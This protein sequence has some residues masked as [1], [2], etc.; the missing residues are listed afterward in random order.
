MNTPR[1]SIYIVSCLVLCDPPSYSVCTPDCHVTVMWVLDIVLSKRIPE[2]C[3]LLPEAAPKLRPLPHPHS[4]QCSTPETNSKLKLKQQYVFIKILNL[5]TLQSVNHWSG[6]VWTFC[7]RCQRQQNLGKKRKM[8]LWSKL[9]RLPRLWVL[10]VWGTPPARREREQ[11]A[12]AGSR[13]WQLLLL[14]P[15]EVGRTCCD[16]RLNRQLFQL[17]PTHRLVSVI[18]YFP[19]LLHTLLQFQLKHKKNR[20]HFLRSEN[21]LTP[22]R[23]DNVWL[24]CSPYVYS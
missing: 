9:L 1:F 7:K 11:A 19:V 2:C 4:T 6:N 20:K 23:Q 13:T 17:Q 18:H 24:V 22:I 5:H 21:L 12:I 3:L 15:G 16:G 14:R 8:I 10:G